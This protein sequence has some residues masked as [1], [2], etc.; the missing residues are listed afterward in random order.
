MIERLFVN[1]RNFLW[2]YPVYI[3]KLYKR[4]SPLS[5]IIT[6]IIIFS[7]LIFY[8]FSIKFFS[9]NILKSNTYRSGLVSEN[10][11]YNPYN[12]NNKTL[13]NDINEL[14]FNTLV[15]VTPKKYYTR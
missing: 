4:F 13:R 14:T 6:C 8:L 12:E 7:L 2:N 10:M 11:I 15:S 5:F 3:S 1:F 9:L